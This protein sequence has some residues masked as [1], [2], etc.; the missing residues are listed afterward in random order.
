VVCT[1]LLWLAACATA[2]TPTPAGLAEAPGSVALN[3]AASNDVPL[4][5]GGHG[6]VFFHGNVYPF[7][8]GGL[9]VDG[10]AVAVLQT[11]GQ[12]YQMRTIADFPG[13]YRGVPAGTSLPSGAGGGLWLSNEHGTLLHFAVPPQGRM[14][15]LSNDALRVVMD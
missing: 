5:G 3:Q 9:G 2:G 14:P 15:S 12:V 11:T 8:I 13:T 4:G 6:T 7:S 10:A 1:S